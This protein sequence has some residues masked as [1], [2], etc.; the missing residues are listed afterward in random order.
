MARAATTVESRLLCTIYSWQSRRRAGDLVEP[1]STL[2]STLIS[3]FKQSPITLTTMRQIQLLA[4]PSIESATD[5]LA[6]YSDDQTVYTIFALHWIYQA[7]SYLIAHIDGETLTE[8]LIIAARTLDRC[9][10]KWPNAKLLQAALEDQRRKRG[11]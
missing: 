3:D 11:R 8:D 5:L 1:I 9:A 10:S 7:A 4:R 6:A 2:P